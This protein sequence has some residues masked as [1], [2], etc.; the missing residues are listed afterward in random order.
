MPL[1]SRF[2]IVASGSG[3]SISQPN[4]HY[5]KDFN[6][7]SKTIVYVKE[8][9]EMIYYYVIKQSRMNKDEIIIQKYLKMQERCRIRQKKYYDKHKETISK[10]RTVT[11]LGGSE[12]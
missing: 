6:E 8:L 1:E 12:R 10:D 7:L 3:F 5:I 2:R 11:E 4:I 9:E